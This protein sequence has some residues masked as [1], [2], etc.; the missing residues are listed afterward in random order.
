MT[1]AHEAM[2]I[3]LRVTLLLLTLSWYQEQLNMVDST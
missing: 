1:S 3:M 2:N